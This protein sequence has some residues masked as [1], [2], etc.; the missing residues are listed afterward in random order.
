MVEAKALHNTCHPAVI[1]LLG[2][3]WTDTLDA[4]V[5]ELL[6]GGDLQSRIAWAQQHGEA[7]AQQQQHMPAQNGG[8]AAGQQQVDKQQEKEARQQEKLRQQQ[9]HKALPWQQRLLISYQLA[10]AVAALH[11]SKP[12]QLLHR[13]VDGR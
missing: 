1:K 5:F 2:T 11:S 10:S 8:R 3:C 4:L 7:P 12:R 9:Q 13:S 6:P